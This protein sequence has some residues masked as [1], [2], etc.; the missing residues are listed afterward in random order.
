[1]RITDLETGGA[2]VVHT[3]FR[4]DLGTLV[5]PGDTLTFERLSAVP[6]TGAFE[7]YFREEMLVLQEDRQHAVVEHIDRYLR[8]VE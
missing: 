1:M 5:L 6:V 4:D 8:E 2:Y 7:L 3:S